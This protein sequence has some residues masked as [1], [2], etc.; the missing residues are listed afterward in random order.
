M[1]AVLRAA[2]SGRGLQPV[3]DEVAAASMR[4]CRADTSSLYVLDGALLHAVAR[5]GGDLA[6]WEYDQA[7]PHELDRTTVVG[8]AALARG[9][10]HIPDVLDD[11]EYTY[12]GPRLGY[13]SLLGVPIIF[14]DELIGGMTLTREEP[15][16]FTDEQIELVQTFA[17]QAAIAIKNARLLETVERQLS[18]QRSVSGVMRSVARSQGLQAVL[19]DI[20][21]S[22]TLL[23]G[24]ENGRLFLLRDGF[25]YAVANSGTDENFE[26]DRA[27]AHTIDRST[28]TGRAALTREPVHIPDVLEDPEYTYAGDGSDLPYRSGVTVPILLDEELIGAFGIVSEETRAFTDEHI[29]APADV[30]RPGRDRHCQRAADRRRRAAAGAAA[31]DRRR[32]RC[33]RAFRGPGGGLRHCGRLGH[34][35]LSRRLRRALPERRRRPRGRRTAVRP[36]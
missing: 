12:G 35:A 18:Q 28:M 26:Y 32:P 7:H 9:P 24:V 8:R 5:A 19:D 17:D 11:S 34:E 13:R 3:L 36:T 14:E 2:A 1:G 31:G 4:L 6:T 30:R 10:A 22:A 15:A 25:L 20:V 29:A 16:S 27:P 23:S 33:R 21:R